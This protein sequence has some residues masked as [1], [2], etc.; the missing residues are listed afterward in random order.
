MSF[1]T[2]GGRF[3]GVGGVRGKEGER[4]PDRG[5]TGNI[6]GQAS[7]DERSFP[8]GGKDWDTYAVQ[9]SQDNGET[10]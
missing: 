5:E 10:E 1:G 6:D 3:V 7:L 4:D 2:I 8:G 9:I